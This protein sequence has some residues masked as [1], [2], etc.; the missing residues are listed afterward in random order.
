MKNRF[1][2]DN[3]E[4]KKDC[5][6]YDCEAEDCIALKALYCKKELCAFYKTREQYE[7]GLQKYPMS[8]A[9]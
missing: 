1:S 3:I 6:A 4:V 8:E 7:E 5:F 9:S 2:Y